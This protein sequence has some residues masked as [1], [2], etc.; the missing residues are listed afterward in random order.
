MKK[1]QIELIPL[2]SAV[3]RDRPTTLD[4]VVRIIPPAPEEEIKR[5]TLN[6]GLVIDRSGSMEGQKIEYARQAACYAV[7][8]LLPAD[9]VSVTV[10]DDRVETLVESTLAVN[11]A[12]ITRKIQTIE[13][14]GS[15]ALHAGWLEGGVQVSKYLN[16][17]HLNRVILLSDG[18]ANV[19]E[20][21]PDIIASDVHGLAERGVSTTTIGVGDDYNE[22][23]MEAIARSGDGNYYYIQSP[24]Q[25]P[26]IFQKELLG[27]MATSGT[28][29]TL[30]IEPQAGVEI[31][32]V[33]NE[34]TVNPN[35]RYRLPNLISGNP[36][37]VVV[38]LKVPP[39]ERETNLCN[40]RLAWNAPK[41]QERQKMRVELQL[42]VVDSAQLEK[43]PLNSEVQQQVAL[44]MA[45]RAKKEAVRL[46]DRGDYEAAN[47]ILE[48]TKMQLLSYSD[49]PMMAPE[50]E[51]LS[52]LQ[53]ELKSQQISSYRKM[54]TSQSYRRSNTHSGGHVSL[55]YAFRRGPIL[56]DITTDLRVDAIVNSTDT[57]LSVKEGSLSGAIHRAAGA[58][59]REECQRLQDCPVGEAKLTR[60]YNLPAEWVIHTACP[61]WQGGDRAEERL[62]AQ[63]YRSCLE[64]AAQNSIRSIAFPAMG[65]G[66]CGFPPQRAAEVAFKETSRFLLTNSSIGEVLFVCLTKEIYQCFRAEFMKVAGW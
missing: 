22:D 3:C 58:E 54:S 47:Q 8:Q 16:P 2:R 50:A 28:G 53:T 51:A 14:R 61:V 7:E 62:L 43:L 19:G 41:V 45:A 36:I 48:Q 30:G 20:T 13:D 1:P 29:V 21:N 23:L 33:L 55:F 39:M 4:V 26:S 37:E 38:R 46:V 31:S 5:P 11:K 17:E 27:L 44:M 12:S 18:L 40:F 24:Q 9:R 66:G 6:I 10:Y 59:L 64:L 63:C 42:P 57:N 49:L 35:G 56:G 25:L 34:L 60:A 52:D 65:T 15:T 32:E